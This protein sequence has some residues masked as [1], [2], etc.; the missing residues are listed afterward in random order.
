MNTF[1]KLIN[2]WKVKSSL[3]LIFILIFIFR[4]GR[5]LISSRIFSPDGLGYWSIAENFKMEGVTN[6]CNTFFKVLMICLLKIQRCA[7]SFVCLLRESPSIDMISKI[8]FGGSHFYMPLAV[9]FNPS[10]LLCI[11]FIN[12]IL[13]IFPLQLFGFYYFILMTS[14][15]GIIN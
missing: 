10:S 5:I 3:F 13:L 9:G 7:S 14:Y 6:F 12:D 2:K 15:I 8:F 11:L 1:T 4:F